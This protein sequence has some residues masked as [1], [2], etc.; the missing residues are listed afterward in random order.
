MDEALAD[1]VVDLSRQY[2]AVISYAQISTT[3]TQ[4]GREQV[5]ESE[6]VAPPCGMSEARMVAEVYLIVE[7]ALVGREK[8][9]C[10][11]QSRLIAQ[12]DGQT[13]DFEIIYGSA[14]Q[15][16]SPGGFS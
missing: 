10:Q 16:D 9:A 4:V 11:G 5:V 15:A 13:P 6:I 12:T 2:I 14:C 1:N 7:F 8:D 3:E